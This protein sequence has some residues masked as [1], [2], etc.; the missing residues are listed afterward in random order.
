MTVGRGHHVLDHTAD[1]VLEAWGPDLASCCEEA[2]AALVSTYTDRV[3]APPSAWHRVHLP[4]ATPTGL[5]LGVLEE[6]IFIL[7][8]AEG[9]APV[10]AEVR[11][12]PDGG[13]EVAL[14]LV[15]LDSIVGTGAVPKAVSRSGLEVEVGRAGA[16]CH[17][18]VDV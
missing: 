8:T 17:V 3:D 4:T 11:A 18:L 9:V 1:V 16:R 15:A 7:D 13:L 5:L 14:G 10:R 6:V 2:V 12:A